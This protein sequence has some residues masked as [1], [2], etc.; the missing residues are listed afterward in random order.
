[1]AIYIKGQ[2]VSSTSGRPVELIGT[3]DSDGN[4]VASDAKAGKIGFYQNL[5]NK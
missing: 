4:I 3:D 2:K 1:M 5:L